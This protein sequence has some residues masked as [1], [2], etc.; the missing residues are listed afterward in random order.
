MP[1]LSSETT[2]NAPPERVFAY[3]ADLPRHSEWAAHP[4]QIERTSEGPVGAGSTFRSSARFMGSHNAEL[5][6]TEFT[7]PS[8]L[9]FEA[10]DDSGQWR[11]EFTLAA[12]NGGTRLTKTS[13]SVRP[14]GMVSRILGAVL[15]PILG[16]KIIAGDMQ[17]IK[18]RVEGSV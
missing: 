13:Q 16:R 7:P 6:V 8:R 18:Q 15:V 1:R 10:T 17:R 12:A 3:L 4:L 2:I 11:H 14:A 5:K 9:T